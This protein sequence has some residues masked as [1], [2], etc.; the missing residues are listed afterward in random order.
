M[1][2]STAPKFRSNADG[3]A[4]CAH[5]DLTVCADCATDETIVEVFGAFYHLPDPADRE[6]L[7]E[8]MAICKAEATL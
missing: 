1:E 7:A 8:D 6:A 3:T 5:R 4:V 2:T